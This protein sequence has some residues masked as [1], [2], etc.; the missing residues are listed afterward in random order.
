MATVE[1]GATRTLA[2]F[3]AEADFA[4]LPPR[5]VEAMKVYLLD[6]LACGFLG[7]AQPWSSIVVDLVRAGGGREEASL[8]GRPWRTTAAQA[9]LANGVMIG[10]FESEHFGHNAHPSGTVFPAAFA[11]AERE[12]CSGRDFLTALTLGYELVCRIGAAQT[13]A[14]ET[15]RGIHN[16]AANGPF[17]AAAAAGR[18][19]GL[20]H[21]RTAQALG[22]AGSH[23]GGLTEFAWDGA[24]TKRLHL[25]RAAQLGLESALLA[26]AGFTGP[27]TILEGRYGYF[28]AYSPAPRG[29]RLLD[30]LGE[31][32]LLEGLVVKAYPC[33]ASSQAL[34]AAIQALKRSGVDV[35]KLER[36]HLRAG[37][38]LLEPRFLNAAPTTMLGAQ[39][40]IP[41]TMA[42]A[43][44]RD[45]DDPASY[46]ESVLTD[47][48][49]RRLAGLVTWE[50]GDPSTFVERRAELDV[51]IAGEQRVLPAVSF[52]GAADS[53]LTFAAA[54]GKFHR[55]AGRFVETA[56]RQRI[57]DAVQ[58]IEQMPDV[59]TLAAEIRTAD[60]QS[61]AA[62]V[63]RGRT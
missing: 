32:W 19:L 2:R 51:T 1:D 62:G 3:A 12:H 25:G 23:C 56:Q 8:F 15:E 34:V 47:P 13:N 59:A 20:D 5:V 58:A 55:F 14:V 36:L 41:F 37:E 22:I 4:A 45:L 53:P 18:L 7:S 42:V 35:A 43:L 39:Y 26:R 57:I 17:G 10:A 61:A 24:M 27:T 28:N 63:E 31:R 44:C 38:R 9:A 30:G 40:S 46:D 21:E 16:P 60:V 29:E 6:D 11:L 33:H 50:Q 52:P 49:I 48:R 54:A